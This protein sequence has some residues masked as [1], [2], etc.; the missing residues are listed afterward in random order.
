MRDDW[1]TARVR[2]RPW[3]PR[4]AAA[5]H[6]VVGNSLASIG[7]WLSWCRHGYS[8]QDAEHWIAHSLCAWDA[9]TEYPFAVV[10]VAT[11][12]L[13]GG[14]GLN[15]Y[16][17]ARKSANLGYWIGDPYANRGAITKAARMTAQFGFEELGLARIEIL[18]HPSNAASLRVAEKLGAVRERLATNSI[19]LEGQPV[20]GWVHSLSPEDAA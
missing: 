20:D 17:A 9:G 13:M 6:A 19:V 2:I 7:R 8:L 1:H 15:R 14:T 12:A 16:D 11:D 10:D 4:D 5:L 18:A 3:L